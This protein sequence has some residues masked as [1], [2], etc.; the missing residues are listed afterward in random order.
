MLNPYFAFGVPVGLLLI[1]AIFAIIR[2]KTKI[3]YLGF[4]LFII[5]GFLTAFCLQVIQYAYHESALTS[6][7]A[8]EESAGYPLWLLFIGFGI[9]LF[10]VLIN[11][12]RAWRRIQKIRN[13]TSD[14]H[15]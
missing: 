5:S 2:K 14:H 1:Y 10:L 3:H 11:L 9:G 6:I 15:N 7:A 4:A 12:V 8:L 13:Q